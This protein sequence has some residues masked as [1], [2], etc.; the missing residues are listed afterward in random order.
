[1]DLVE[2]LYRASSSFPKSEL[3][4]LTS[5]IRRAA[6]SIPS[7]IAEGQCRSTTRA[8]LP[9]LGIAQGSVAEV[10]TQVM[11]AMRL[12]YLTQEAGLQLMD[13]AGEVGRLI[14]GLCASLERRESSRLA[15]SH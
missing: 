3:Y 2:T 5:Q 10:E 6:V 12:K 1:M 9:H 8:F 15:T 11:I 13:S 4:G 14:R 7:N